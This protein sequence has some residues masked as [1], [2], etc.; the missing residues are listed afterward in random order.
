MAASGT[1]LS[2]WR[3]GED[4]AL[5][6]ID[7]RRVGILVVDFITPVVDSPEMFGEIAAANA[8]SDV[9]AMAGRFFVALNVVCFSTERERQ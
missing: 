5:W 2:S 7:E 1:M 4:A 6:P 9:F 8:L 3:H